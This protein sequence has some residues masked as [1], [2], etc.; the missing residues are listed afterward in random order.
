MYSKFWAKFPAD[1]VEPTVKKLLEKLLS[2]N[3]EERPSAT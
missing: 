1:E 3:P 2:P